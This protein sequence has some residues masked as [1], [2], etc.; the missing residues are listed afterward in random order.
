M[1]DCNKLDHCS[2]L[3]IVVRVGCSTRDS[4]TQH[5]Q[6]LNAEITSLAA[7]SHPAELA[8]ESQTTLCF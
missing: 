5:S 4:P 1:E 8:M 3:P 6:E 7:A 2:E